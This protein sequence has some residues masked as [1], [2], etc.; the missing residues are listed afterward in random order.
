MDSGAYLNQ[1][2]SGRTVTLSQGNS[3]RKQFHINFLLQKYIEDYKYYP[4]NIRTTSILS[5]QKK[6]GEK[7]RNSG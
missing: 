1:K 3:L 7:S 5:A 2:S 4:L 6:G